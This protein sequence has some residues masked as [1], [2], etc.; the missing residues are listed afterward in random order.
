MCFLR[1]SATL[2]LPLIGLFAACPAA[3][4]AA[5][6]PAKGKA[7][8]AQ[9]CASCHSI[10]YNGAGPSHGGLLG[11]KA[12]TVS[13]FVYS[14]ALKAS[15]VTWSDETLEK[16]LSDP[17]KLIPGQKMW[18]SVPDSAERQNIIAYL[19]TETRK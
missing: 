10:E 17:E 12:G 8:Y 11:R 6:D 3:A 15:A 14:A 4:I 18:I 16:W 1:L 13:N 2:V 19:R 7:A 5:G 9:R